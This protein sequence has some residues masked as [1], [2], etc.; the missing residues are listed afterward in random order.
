MHVKDALF[1]WPQRGVPACSVRAVCST[2][3]YSSPAGGC[4]RAA[5]TRS[6]RRWRK[7]IYWP[8][9]GLSLGQR[10]VLRLPRRQQVYFGRPEPRVEQ[11]DSILAIIAL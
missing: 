4:V 5:A 2:F 10:P 1:G 8:G 6:G 11:S 9:N 3:A 7:F